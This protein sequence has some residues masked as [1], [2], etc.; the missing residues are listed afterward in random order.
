MPKD[1]VD[2]DDELPPAGLPPEVIDTQALMKLLEDED[3]PAEHAELLGV[4]QHRRNVGLA[5]ITRLP[6][7]QKLD[8][9]AVAQAT[10]R[11]VLLI[12]CE[13]GAKWIKP[14][15]TEQAFC[16]KCRKRLVVA[17]E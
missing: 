12:K 14:T 5:R 9:E 4:E 17:V 1:P 3:E 16:P 7:P 2:T 6:Q 11:W 8:R 13:C 10:A 15:L